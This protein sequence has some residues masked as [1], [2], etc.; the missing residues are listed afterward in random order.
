MSTPLTPE[1]APRAPRPLDALPWARGLPLLGSAVPMFL[2]PMDFLL[3]EFRRLGP[4]FR[5]RALHH[6]FTVLA[7]PEANALLGRTADRF[8]AA[9]PS[10]GAFSREFNATHVLPGVDGALHYKL[11]RVQQQAYSRGTIAARL[12]ETAQ[13][14]RRVLATYRPGSVKLV[15]LCRHIVTEQLGALILGRGPGDYLDD[16]ALVVRFALNTRFTQQWPTQL[17]LLP[18]YQRAKKRFLEFGRDILEGRDEREGHRPE[19][20]EDLRAALAAEPGFISEADR[21]M[22]ALGPFIAGIDTVANTVAFMVA[23]LLRL[24][25]AY[26]RVE[27]DAHALLD[28]DAPTVQRLVAARALQGALQEA[29]RLYPV[30]PLIY[31]HTAQSLEFGGYLLPKGERVLFGT[32]MFHRMPEHFPEPDRFDI[33]RSHHDIARKATPLAAYGLGPH[34]CAGS[35]FAEVQMLLV[36]A[37]LLHHARFALTP[38]A[39]APRVTR[40]PAPTLGQ[41]FMVELLELRT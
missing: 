40:D 31:R 19:L 9:A 29:L 20:L 1:P 23:A 15:P 32:T 34:A 28:D 7:G 11:R 38:D 14:A 33:D 10:W 8:L 36:A 12:P 41:R 37:T 27:A 25:D 16:I 39:P 4:I 3:G 30:A 18:R 22:L 26:A 5:L 6:R 21:V 35:G 13:I 2:D 24:P 17:L